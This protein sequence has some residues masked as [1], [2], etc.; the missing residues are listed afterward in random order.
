MWL[1]TIILGNAPTTSHVRIH[2]DEGI[3]I[4]NSPQNCI[5]SSASSSDFWEEPHYSDLD[6][7]KS[8]KKLLRMPI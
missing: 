6:L 1:G 2:P 3:K 4:N 7:L 5:F 8:P